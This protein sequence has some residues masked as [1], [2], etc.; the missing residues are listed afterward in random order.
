MGEA[1]QWWQ[2]LSWAL[3]EADSGELILA[4]VEFALRS[5]P[6]SLPPKS[7][8]YPSRSANARQAAPR[9]H[10]PMVLQSRNL[11]TFLILALSFFVAVVW[12]FEPPG[13]YDDFP[14]GNMEHLAA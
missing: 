6:L 8:P 10:V 12:H 11:L 2:G 1:G 9:G 4:H 13:T 3:S 5:L 14:A 7:E